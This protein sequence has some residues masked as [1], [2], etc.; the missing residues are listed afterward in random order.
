MKRCLRIRNDESLF[1]IRDF[2][3]WLSSYRICLQSR[4]TS[5]FDPGL[6]RST[7]GKASDPSKHGGEADIAQHE[8]YSNL[9]DGSALRN[10]RA[11]EGRSRL[12]LVVAVEEMFETG[13]GF[14][15]SLAATVV[16]RIY[17]VGNH[18]WVWI[19]SERYRLE[20]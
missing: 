1:R 8:K 7:E 3:L 11:W 15:R 17:P 18:L 20:I 12:E 6:G 14:G 10:S 16:W 9:K 2:P 5:S 19:S 4:E 13:L